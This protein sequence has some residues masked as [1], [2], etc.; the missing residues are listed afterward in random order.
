M[1][2]ERRGGRGD[3][4]GRYGAV[5]R[6]QDEASEGRNQRD[7][8]YR[9]MDYRSYM[10]DFNSQEPTN[11]YDDSSEE[12]SV[13]DSYEASSGS[14]TQRRKRD[15]PSE[16][17]G[18]P[19]DG[20][21][22]DQDY[23]TEQE[24]EEQKASSII[25]LR[26][27]PQSATENDIRAQLQAHGFQPREVRLMR[28]KA[29]GQSR[30]FAF[31]EFNHLQDATRWMEA[32]QH[33]LTILG[34]KVSM[35]YSDPKPKINEDWLCSKCGVQNFKRR[36]KCFKCGIPR[37][38]AEQK[39]P[40]GSRLDQLVALSGR[41]LSQGLLPLP[42]P[43]QV[44]A[45][46]SAQPAAQ[47]SEPCA[48]NA[49]DTIILRNLNPHSTMD[50]ILSALAPY[51][52]LSS[53]N[54]RVIKDKQT[55]LN[56]G[57]AFIQLSTIVEA[58]QLLQILQALHPPLN[59]DGKT[60]NVEF[61]KG[62]KR[63]MSSSDGNRISAASVASTA[64]AAAQWAISQASQGSEA[65][66][67]A[68]EEQ[69][70]D[71]GYYQQDE[72]YGAQ[73][74]EASMYSQAYLKGSQ[75]QTGTSGAVPVGKADKVHSESTGA[76]DASLEPGVPGIDS[77]PVLP[78]FPRTTQ[79]TAVPVTYQPPGS[80][81]GTSSA[82]GNATAAQSQSYT[83]VSPAVLKPD[84]PSAAQPST[85]T[86]CISTSTSNLPVTS[87]VGQ[88]PYMQYPV[89]DV[90]T[91]Q[92]DES[93]GYY[94]DPLTGLY[95]DP[96][97]QYYYNA[98]TQQYLYWEGERRTY[99]PASDQASDGHKDGS[100]SGGGSGKEG[101]E[102]KEKHKT[103]T[104]QQI[105]KDMERWARSL[106]KQK[107]NFKNSFQPVSSIREDERRESATADAGYAI[108]E[109][110]G[111]LAERQHSGMD[112]SKLA[113]DD[114]LSPPRGL[115]AAYSGESDS[116]EEQE[117][118]ADREE[119]LTDWHKLACLLCRRQFPSKEALIRHQQLSGLHKQNLEIHRRAHLS[120]Q[121][122]EA[123]EKNDME[124]MK[125][126]DRAAER[127]EKYGVP[128]PPEPKKRKY[129]A[130]TPATVD[131][132]QPTRDGL[133]SDNIGS[134]MLQAMGWKEGSGLGRK[135]QGIVAPI[136]AQ[137]RVRGSGLG[138]R[139]SS[140]GAAASE[141][142]REALHKTMLTRFNESE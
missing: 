9:D 78:T 36:E 111:A 79:T 59:I 43:Y 89:P 76:A 93:S 102:K 114:R 101:K 130:V 3:R 100:S 137:T 126:R 20:D 97:S 110:K 50:S 62:S 46:L 129:S 124:Q 135:K 87:S 140:Y 88:E 31:V 73:G 112:L 68:Q 70:V 108:L 128:E 96:N 2:Y 94:Y 41:E 123:L 14:E 117:K 121:E 95:Y 21:Y 61:A 35:H 4:T 142:Y 57:F 8:D 56:R 105:A 23:R 109:K 11:D 18:F 19:G 27:L 75:P 49:N 47:M 28:N 10:R 48:E 17:L 44:S 66:W 34:Q 55:Q 12:H 113:G 83:I 103:K 99:V 118:A 81:D 91:Y 80:M 13:E 119:K 116:E 69:S 77:V 32:N 37:S 74:L 132:E 125:Y 26:M 85:A 33:S 136:E 52:V 127:R 30:G 67:A 134:R 40:P 42:Q 29:S 22:R 65:G 122:L 104:A 71:Y 39:L 98:Q 82:Q 63:D 6:N 86:Q 15:S 54:V 53:S 138:A 60:I 133:G 16:Q 92:Y 1:E 72:A 106:N 25:M 84:V 45:A 139:G 141:S 64:I 5:D 115:V 107:E 120:E 58:A 131:F 51:A 90:S 24:E 38:E 7:H